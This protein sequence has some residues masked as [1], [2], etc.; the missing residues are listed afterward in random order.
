ML[1]VVGSD[2]M[3]A[4]AFVIAS[5]HDIAALTD[6]LSWRVLQQCGGRATSAV[7]TAGSLT[8]A[9]F[10]ALRAFSRRRGTFPATGYAGRAER[11]QATFELDSN[12]AQAYLRYDYVNEWMLRPSNPDVHRRLLAL[13]GKLPERE[14]LWVETRERAMPLPETV[15][16]WTA[17]SQQFPDYPPFLMAAADPIIHFGPLYGIPISDARPMLDRLDQLV[18]DHADSK[19]HQAI[20]SDAVGTPLEAADA[21]KRRALR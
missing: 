7:P 15:A 8:T 12:F 14:R 1:R 20:M 21:R 2:S 17:L 18:P 11:V 6:S 10:D 9:S 4:K 13:S 16:A 19:L 5:P 3:L